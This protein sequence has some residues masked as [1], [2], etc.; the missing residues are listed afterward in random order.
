MPPD[1]VPK[2][3]KVR[4]GFKPLKYLYIGRIA[5]LIQAGGFTDRQTEE[6]AL[7]RM[8]KAGHKADI[9]R[10]EIDAELASSFL[11]ILDLEGEIMRISLVL[12][13]GKPC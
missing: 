4:V 8:F 12:D 1:N 6:L 5:H 3:I 2:K 13:D 9:S 10:V 7:G 11:S